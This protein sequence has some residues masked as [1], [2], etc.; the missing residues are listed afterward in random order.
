MKVIVEW[1]CTGLF[2][3]RLGMMEAGQGA[4]K[5][6]S[7]KQPYSASHKGLSC[8]WPRHCCWWRND[9]RSARCQLRSP[10]EPDGCL[11]W[12]A[13]KCG[14]NPAHWESQQDLGVLLPVVSSSKASSPRD[15]ECSALNF[16]LSTPFWIPN[17]YFL[18]LLEFS[19]E[20]CS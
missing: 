8:H 19:F 15:W 4:E 20:N 11:V 17:S 7:R 14:R 13:G 9:P 18:D 3:S 2:L 1:H 10:T 16:F 12:V 5:E 6:S